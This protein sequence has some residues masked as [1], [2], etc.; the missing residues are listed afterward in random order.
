MIDHAPFATTGRRARTSPFVFVRLHSIHGTPRSG[1]TWARP[2]RIAAHVSTH[3]GKSGGG[4]SYG[5]GSRRHS[6]Q[7]APSLSASLGGHSS[8]STQ[9]VPDGGSSQRSGFGYKNAHSAFSVPQSCA[10]LQGR[11]SVRHSPGVAAGVAA[12]RRTQSF[13]YV[14]PSQPHTGAGGSLQNTCGGVHSPIGAKQS[15]FWHHHEL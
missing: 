2:E 11:A 8:G 12:S 6:I 7:R 9:H 15:G 3:F 5:S 14:M 4:M 10:L 1:R 13:Q